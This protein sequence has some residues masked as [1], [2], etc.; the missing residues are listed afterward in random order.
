MILMYFFE[1]YLDKR[2]HTALKLPTLPKTL[3]GVISQEKFVKSRAYSLDKRYI[4]HFL[5][6]VYGDGSYVSIWN[7]LVKFWHVHS[8]I[9]S[10]CVI[11]YSRFH[12][13]HEFVTI[14]IYSAILLFRV[15]PWFWKVSDEFCLVVSH[16]LL[17]HPWFVGNFF[18]YTAEIQ[19]FCGVTWPQCW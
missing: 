4:Y 12:F 16:L 13:V 5:L 9:F 7:L 6:I 18:S 14:L 11:T 17:N 8:N 15:L 10:W 2:Q 19:R 3:E 1:T